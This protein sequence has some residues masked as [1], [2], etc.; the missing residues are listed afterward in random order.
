[1]LTVLVMGMPKT[2]AGCPYHSHT[3][4]PTIHVNR[5]VKLCLHYTEILDSSLV[6]RRYL[7]IHCP[8]EVWEIERA[9][10]RVLGEYLSVT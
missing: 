1:M 10:E 3:G 9:R 5:S 7:L 6:A 2:R 8:R 4:S